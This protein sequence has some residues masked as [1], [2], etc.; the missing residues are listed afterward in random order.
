MPEALHAASP[1]VFISVFL[2]A[3]MCVC[4][5]AAL[6]LPSP[7]ALSV[8][9]GISIGQI[10]TGIQYA[11]RL[12]ESLIGCLMSAAAGSHRERQ[13]HFK[14][15]TGTSR[16]RLE[17]SANTTGSTP[18]TCCLLIILTKKD[19]V[20]LMVQRKCCGSVK[21]ERVDQRTCLLKLCSIMFM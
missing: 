14:K 12:I 10:A 15:L 2:C 9:N 13:S 16:T 3:C 17:R 20:S 11:D 7:S 5:S 6:Y 1:S 18:L 19:P 8:C 4:L 21:V